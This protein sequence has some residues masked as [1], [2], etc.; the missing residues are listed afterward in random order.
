MTTM[1]TTSSKGKMERT[2]RG[3]KVESRKTSHCQTRSS[4]S[5]P[6]G[7]PRWCRRSIPRRTNLAKSGKG[8]PRA[9]RKASDRRRG[10][11]RPKPSAG[12]EPAPVKRKEV[13][14]V[15]RPIGVCASIFSSSTVAVRQG[16][17]LQTTEEA[18]D[19]PTFWLQSKDL[20]EY[21][22]FFFFTQI[23]FTRLANNVNPD[24]VFV[25]EPQVIFSQR[26][27]DAHALHLTTQMIDIKLCEAKTSRLSCLI[28]AAL[29]R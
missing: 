25:G 3:E 10:E 18:L 8:E 27:P 29:Q 22:R 6:R 24:G 4:V 16:H 19:E 20:P 21:T 2:R 1:T 9:P 17:T 26:E 11:G 14:Q 15:E 13:S 12:R 7:S 28:K 5:R 23:G